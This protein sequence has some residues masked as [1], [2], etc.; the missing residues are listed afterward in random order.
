VF[1][2]LFKLFRW[3]DEVLLNASYALVNSL[4]GTQRLKTPVKIEH[5]QVIGPS[6]DVRLYTSD[7]GE[8]V[9]SLVRVVR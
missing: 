6:G 3:R 1:Y 7:G 2:A 5:A 8:Y 4:T 9:M